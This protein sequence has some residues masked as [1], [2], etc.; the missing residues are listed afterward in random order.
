MT[1][2]SNDF[3]EGIVTS[4]SGIQCS[5]FTNLYLYVLTHSFSNIIGCVRMVGYKFDWAS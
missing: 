2:I 5:A 1:T 3:L 4:V